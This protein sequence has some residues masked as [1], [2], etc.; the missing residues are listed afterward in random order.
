MMAVSYIF[1]PG[2]ETD[3][4]HSFPMST[5]LYSRQQGQYMRE[6]NGKPTGK[7]SRFHSKK[8]YEMSQG[9]CELIFGVRGRPHRPQM[10]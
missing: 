7:C 5:V 9:E 4:T 10:K 3:V 2:R 1:E 6:N 8:K